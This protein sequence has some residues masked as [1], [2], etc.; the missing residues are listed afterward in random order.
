[1]NW[2]FNNVAKKKDPAE[3]SKRKSGKTFSS[4]DVVIVTHR[5]QIYA[6]IDTRTEESVGQKNWLSLYP[7]AL[8]D[9]LAGLSSE[10][11]AEAER[12]AE[13]WSDKGIPAEE[14]RV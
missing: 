11:L 4:R 12:L 7:Q 5:D 9:V 3:G 1:V 13:E 14:Q 8:S 6:L 10:E 2:F